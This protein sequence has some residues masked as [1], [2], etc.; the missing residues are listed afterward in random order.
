MKLSDPELNRQLK[1]NV[2]RFD[3]LPTWIKDVSTE[4]SGRVSQN[5]N[6]QSNQIGSE[7]I[8]SPGDCV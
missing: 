3:Q 2:D 7:V 6:E 8:E 1:A 4:P 5:V